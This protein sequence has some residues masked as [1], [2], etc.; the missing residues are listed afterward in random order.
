MEVLAPLRCW[1]LPWTST[2]TAG[3]VIWERSLVCKISIEWKK[4][5]LCYLEV[6]GTWRWTLIVTKNDF[7]SV[8]ELR[9]LEWVCFCLHLWQRKVRTKVDSIFDPSSIVDETVSPVYASISHTCFFS[10]WFFFNKKNLSSFVNH[11]TSIERLLTWC[12]CRTLCPSVFLWPEGPKLCLHNSYR[13]KA[14][15]IKMAPWNTKVGV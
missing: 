3:G 12:V 6:T 9:C 11:I 4:N 14:N 10:G 15:E 13:G 2:G 1:G 7:Q 5:T 8:R